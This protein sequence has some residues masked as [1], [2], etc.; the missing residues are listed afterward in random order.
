M[1][2]HTIT[3]F[4]SILDTSAPFFRDVSVVID[5]IKEGKSKDLVKKIRSEKDKSKRNEIKKKLPSICFSGV[6]NKREDKSLVEHSGII[7]LD[8][9][10]YTSNK[11]MMAE[12]EALKKSKYTYSV[13]V[14]PS[15]KGL[16]ALIKIPAD[17]DNHKSYFNSLAK[18]YN[19]PPFDVTSKNVSRV[20]Y[21][22]YDP[23]IYVNEK[24][25]LW[26]TVEVEGH[27]TLVREKPH[28]TIGITDKKK[29]VDI[30]TKWGIDKH[31]IVEGQRNQNTYIWAAAFNDFGVDKSLTQYVLGVY[32]SDGFSHGEIMQ[33]IE[34]AYRDQSKHGSKVYENTDKINNIRSKVRRGVSKQ[35]IRRDLNDDDDVDPGVVDSVLNEI[36]DEVQEQAFWTKSD[37]GV[38]KNIP[39]SFKTFLEKYGFYKFYPEGGK[40]Y[41][42]VKVT[43]NLIDHTTDK[44]IKDFLLE[45][46][47]E[48][49]DMS[50]YNYFADNTRFF[51]EEFLSLLGTIDV[52]FIA[53][54]KTEAYLYYQNCAIKITK[55]GVTEIDYLDLGGYVWKEHIIERNY[56]GCDY[57]PCQYRKFIHNICA[58][59]TTR[60]ASMESTIGF[61]LHGYKNHGYCPAVILNDE[62]ISDSP[63]GGTG[64]GL[65]MQALGKM[66]K[67]VKID[68]KLLDFSKGFPYQLVSAD[69]QILVF[70]DIKK[71]FQFENL[72]SVVTEGLTLEKKNKDA[73][74][75]PFENSPKIAITTNYAVMGTGNSFDRR[76]W[77][78]ELHPHY[79]KAFTPQDEA[80]GKLMFADWG[81]DEW[82]QFDSYQIKNLIGF[83]NTGL[84]E[85]K[86]VNLDVRRLSAATCHEFIEWCGLING[87]TSTPVLLSNMK[88]SKLQLYL[89]FTGEN[90]DF[91]PR[92]KMYVS[93]TK[94]YKWLGSYCEFKYGTKPEEGRDSDRG[95][96]IRFVENKEAVK[97]K[98]T[99]L[100]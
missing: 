30:L 72:F 58:N 74:M 19:S 91:A 85:S 6:F 4:R 32:A 1:S 23:Q 80:N 21:E 77:E 51:K 61:L 84:I 97:S 93:M 41:V 100:L 98:Q 94:F 3:I 7:C 92:G 14:S 28:L 24:S 5:R 22:S 53:D 63:E 56:A 42:F 9:D 11:E 43:N 83:L 8:F 99:E 29:V 55:D 81:E 44:E 82:C 16:K 13:F 89:E 46:L 17:A 54:T 76:K 66:K 36:I 10:D 31:P 96:W 75:I 71:Y 18:H 65:F 49:D 2:Q 79:T 38:V 57:S 60:I 67:L 64:K 15:G 39:L 73:I 40:N 48:L 50:V 52:Y 20:C 62:V 37:K 34:S 68:G 86:F 27:D 47:I 59:D 87:S 12:K 45:Y 78:L 33:T 70:D 69:T 26:D 90:A 25:H 88:L 35:S 95:R